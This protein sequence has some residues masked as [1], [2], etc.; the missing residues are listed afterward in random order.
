MFSKR[1]IKSNLLGCLELTLFMRRGV[2]RFESSRVAAI[3]SFLI[4]LLVLPPTLAVMVALSEGYAASLLVTLHAIRIVLSMVLF[5]GAVYFI[6][7]QYD[8]QSYFYK[9]INIFNWMNIPGI[10]LCLPILSIIITGASIEAFESYAVFITLLGY[11]Y[12]AFIITHTF[13]IPWEMGG[14]IAII[15]LAIDQNALELT[16]HIRDMLS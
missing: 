15:S 2:V 10:I 16:T 5:L 6:T 12:G 11:V 14:F 3:K 4:T 8:R 13:R 9:F 1:E 7:K